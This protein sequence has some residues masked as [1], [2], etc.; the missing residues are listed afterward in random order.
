MFLLVSF[1]DGRTALQ[2]AILDN[3]LVVAQH[4]IDFGCD[5]NVK[6]EVL[7]LCSYFN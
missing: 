7:T 1:Q 5:V 2:H 4:L 3:E 6:D